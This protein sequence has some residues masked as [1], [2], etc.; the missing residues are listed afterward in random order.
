[1]ECYWEI[2]VICWVFI[3]LGLD[4]SVLLGWFCL[5]SCSRVGLCSL[6]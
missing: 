2:V 6:F 1:M 4:L 3:E 5:V